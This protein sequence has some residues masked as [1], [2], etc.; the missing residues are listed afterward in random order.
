[1]DRQKRLRSKVE[2]SPDLLRASRQLATLA[3]AQ[4]DRPLGP[5]EREEL[6]RGLAVAGDALG[7]SEMLA[8]DADAAVEFALDVVSLAALGVESLASD[9][10]EERATKEAEVSRL[11]D[12]AAYARSLAEDPN[13]TYP[14]E[15]TYSYTARDPYH[16]LVTKTARS[17]VSNPQEALGAAGALQK[18]IES[19]GKLTDLMVIDLDQRR[20][21]LD[22]MTARLP[23][24]VDSSRTLLNEVIANLS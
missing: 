3:L 24:F 2:K 8:V 21:R 15:I 11:T 6:R 16:G 5:R 14:V 22:A 13:A 17:T 4:Q 20:G 7:W 23:D 12:I 10:A 1:M 18:S 9:L 19:R